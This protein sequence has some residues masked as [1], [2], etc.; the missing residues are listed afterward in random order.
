MRDQDGDPGSGVTTAREGG[1]DLS[2]P[3]PARMYDYYLGGVHNFAVDRRAAADVLSILPETRDFALRNRAFLRRVVRHLAAEAG[4][5]Q[6]LDL[7]SGIP[8]VGNVHEIAQDV[9]PACRVVYVDHEPVAVAHSRKLLEGNDNAAVIQADVRDAATV[10]SHPDTRRLLDFDRPL[11][12]LMLQ[13]LPFVPEA[14]NPRG[15]VAAYRAACV[16]GSYLALA[17][18]LTPEFWPGNVDQAIE[19]YRSSTHPLHLRT[20]EQV[21]ALFEGYELVEPGVVFT[22]AWRPDRPI[23]QQDAIS[24]RAVAGLGRLPSR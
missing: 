1:V 18:S 17:H 8:T 15:I 9:N 13:V 3:N 21:A 10:L 5:V 7:G 4:I 16:P 14:D 11:A 22:A 2:R 12:V 6:F 20:P 24:S 19:L 23:H